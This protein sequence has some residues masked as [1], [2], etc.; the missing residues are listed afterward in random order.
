MRTINLEL[1]DTSAN[2][3]NQ[4]SEADKAKLSAF[5]QFW[6]LS[7]TGKEKSSAL[8]AMRSIQRKVASK[9]LSPE[10]VQELI[11]DSIT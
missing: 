11:N 5:V 7:F 4:L 8:E 2:L 1:P 9:N 3:I 10:E 6:L